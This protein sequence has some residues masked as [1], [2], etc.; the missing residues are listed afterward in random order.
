MLII[1]GTIALILPDRKRCNSG[2]RV[3]IKRERRASGRG[4]IEETEMESR[5]VG[6]GWERERHL[7]QRAELTMLN[8]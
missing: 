4:C 3:E 2:G 7:L 5:G 6:V 8:G 1:V